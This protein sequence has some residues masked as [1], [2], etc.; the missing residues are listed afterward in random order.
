[1]LEIIQNINFYFLQS[2]WVWFIGLVILFYKANKLLERHGE[3][4]ER[5]NERNDALEMWK[6]KL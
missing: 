5:L 4:I 2:A 6:R 1:M 3:L